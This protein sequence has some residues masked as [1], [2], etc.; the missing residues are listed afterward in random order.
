MHSIKEKLNQLIKLH[1]YVSYDQ[2]A[3]YCKELGCK[4]ETA[5][6]KL[7]PSI[8]PNV[9]PVWNKNAIAG[10]KWKGQTTTETRPI[11]D[12]CAK[13]YKCFS[14]RKF[15]VCSCVKEE[16]KEASLF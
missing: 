12:Q 4:L 5:T 10:Y 6:R 1:G 14:Y 3:L 2:I 16:V 7:R 13:D 15:K 11:L 9:D 8:S